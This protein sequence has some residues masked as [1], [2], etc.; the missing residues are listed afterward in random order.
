MKKNVFAA[1]IFISLIFLLL[2]YKACSHKKQKNILM[3]SSAQAT[4]LTMTSS[5]VKP[6][7]FVNRVWAPVFEN[8]NADQGA[9]FYLCMGTPLFGYELDETWLAIEIEK[10]KQC[11]LL[12]NHVALAK[13]KIRHS[14]HDEIRDAIIESAMF[15][16]EPIQQP[17]NHFNIDSGFNTAQ[18]LHLIYQTHSMKIPQTAYELYQTGTPIQGHSCQ[19]ADIVFLI[20]TKDQKKIV[21]FLYLDDNYLF[22]F[23]EKEKKSLIIDASKALNV[24]IYQIKNGQ[25]IGKYFI[26]LRTFFK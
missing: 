3:L 5:T 6:I 17:S 9:L 23:S 16:L 11:Y 7:A 25:C 13:N 14:M 18:L 19:P 24:D 4:S 12:Q 15:F 21:P 20:D 22:Y 26:F 1:Y 8:N 10:K 2:L